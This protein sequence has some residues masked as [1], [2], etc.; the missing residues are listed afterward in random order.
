MIEKGKISNIQAGML[1]ITSFTIM[2]HLIVLTVVI[3]F[4]K[5]DGWIVG[6]IGTGLG[7]IGIISLVKLS[8]RFPGLTLIEIL[9][10]HFSWIG[11]LI[12]ILYLF[13]FLIM[14][15]LAARLYAE[16]YKRIMMETP[17]WATITVILLSTYIVYK[18][19]ETLARLNQVMLPILVLFAIAVVVLTMGDKKDYTNLLPFF[20]NGL[21][22]VSIGSL[23]VMGWIGEFV[24]M[25]MVLPYVQQL[26]KIGKNRYL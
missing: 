1:A 4:S 22:P 3:S 19:L 5:Q 16:A 26:K 8:Q 13:Y 17:M 24:I 20:G 6:I 2:G 14:V 12:S 23:V 21:Y 10:Q 15:C 7:C 11:K 18:G 25:G 9:C